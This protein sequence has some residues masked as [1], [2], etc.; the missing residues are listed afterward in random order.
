MSASEV[1]ARVRVH[2]QPLRRVEQLDEQA[3]R[4]A[5]PLDVGAPEPGLRL[6]LDRVAEEPAVLEA[7]QTGLRLVTTR[8]ST[9]P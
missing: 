7:G 9:R 2:G 3:G 1:A 8:G 4:R 6:G 5:E